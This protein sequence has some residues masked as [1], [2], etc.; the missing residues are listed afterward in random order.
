M[1]KSKKITLATLKSFIRK[2]NGNLYIN[3]T[4]D[5]NGMTDCVEQVSNGV[6]KCVYENEYE[7]YTLGIKGVWVVGGTRNYFTSF[8]DDKFKGI[9]VSNCCGSFV[10][11]VVK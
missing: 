11:M 4:S 7:R 9:K 2:N 1:E 10:V 3:V 6:S 8:E 5:F